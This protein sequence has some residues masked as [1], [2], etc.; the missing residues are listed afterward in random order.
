MRK[1]RYKGP[2]CVLA[3]VGPVKHNEFIYLTE[4]QAAY[5]NGKP[6]FVMQRDDPPEGLPEDLIPQNGAGVDLTKIPWKGGKTLFK[7]FKELR[8]PMLIKILTAMEAQGIPLPA[9]NLHR[10]PEPVLRETAL[11]LARHAG[12]L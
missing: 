5:V 3:G 8:K 2:N 1:A 9:G 12:W 10:E 6:R 4:E 11:E 7:Y